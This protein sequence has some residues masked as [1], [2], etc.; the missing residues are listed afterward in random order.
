MTWGLQSY[1]DSGRR[2]DIKGVGRKMGKTKKKKASLV[3]R[4]AARRAYQKVKKAPLA[5]G[6]RFA[7]VE[8]SAAAGGAKTPGAVAA[9]IGRKKYGKAK[10]QAMAVKGR[11]KSKK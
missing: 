1:Q 8:R 10:F 2:E 5:S 11:K 7:A 9:W 4:R 3:G 6:A